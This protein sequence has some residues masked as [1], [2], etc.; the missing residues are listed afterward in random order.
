MKLCPLGSSCARGV[1]AVF[2]IAGHRH[3][4]ECNTETCGEVQDENLS[5]VK[6]QNVINNTY[7]AS[8]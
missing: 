2:S 1:V 4:H 3:P 5:K 7:S 6:T 8:Q